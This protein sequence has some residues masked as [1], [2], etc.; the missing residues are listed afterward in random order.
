MLDHVTQTSEKAGL[1]L[2]VIQFKNLHQRSPYDPKFEDRSQEET[3]RQER[4]VRG[5]AILNLKE[6]NKTT[7]FPTY[8]AA[9][10]KFER[11]RGF[12]TN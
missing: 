7:F 10:S 1:S 3:E 4:C 5:D 8:N 2:G 12:R 11:F 6:K 9:R